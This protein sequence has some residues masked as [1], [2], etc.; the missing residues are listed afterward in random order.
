MTQ[1]KNSK[2][3]LQ[4][5]ST[6]RIAMFWQ[7]KTKPLIEYTVIAATIFFPPKSHLVWKAV[8]HF[9]VLENLV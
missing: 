3:F 5:E 9:M 7:L 4:Q 6:K 8:G 2:L 1:K